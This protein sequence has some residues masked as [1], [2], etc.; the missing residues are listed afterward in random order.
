VAELVEASLNDPTELARII[1]V[2]TRYREARGIY[3]NAGGCIDTTREFSRWVR[4]G[5]TDLTLPAH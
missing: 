4:P 2:M 1:A 3:T 5:T